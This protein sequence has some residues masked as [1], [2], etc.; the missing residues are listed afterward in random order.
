MSGNFHKSAMAT[1]AKN[2]NRDQTVNIFYTKLDNTVTSALPQ[3]GFS[4]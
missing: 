2:L 4:T 3:K 1:C